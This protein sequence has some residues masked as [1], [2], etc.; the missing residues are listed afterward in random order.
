V[1]RAVTGFVSQLSDISKSCLLCKD[2]GLVQIAMKLARLGRLCYVTS[3]EASSREHLR[4]TAVMREHQAVQFEELLCCD[5][6][7]CLP[8]LCRDG[9]LPQDMKAFNRHPQLSMTSF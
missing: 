5:C 8:C 9:K 1:Y 4:L 6:H 2:P 3:T 7:T